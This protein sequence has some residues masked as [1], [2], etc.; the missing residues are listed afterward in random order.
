MRPPP[1]ACSVR[2]C[3][4]ALERHERRFVCA[5]GHSYDIARSGYVSLLQPQDR[6]STDAGDTRAAVDA[7]ARLLASGV[8][9]TI[10]HRFVEEAASLE[11]G[12]EPAVIDLGSGSGDV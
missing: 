5:R 8:A 3:G 2:A 12:S 1:L 7:R 10:L 11:L 6:R 4:L 9:V